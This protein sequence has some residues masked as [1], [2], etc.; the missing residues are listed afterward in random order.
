MLCGFISEVQHSC[1][2]DYFF[3]IFIE[4]FTWFVSLVMWKTNPCL[5]VSIYQEPRRKLQ[6]PIRS[7]NHVVNFHLIKTKRATELTR[8]PSHCLK[9]KRWPTFT[10]LVMLPFNTFTFI[11]GLLSHFISLSSFM[12]VKLLLPYFAFVLN[13]LKFLLD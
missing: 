7:L 4:V 10:V 6:N 13:G 3:L 9:A 12:Q 2:K 8:F 5:M 1:L 11:P